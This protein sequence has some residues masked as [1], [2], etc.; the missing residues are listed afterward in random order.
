M[1]KIILSSL[2]CLFI[3]SGCSQINTDNPDKAFRYWT[4]IPLE[5]DQ[6]TVYKGKYWQSS[7]YSLEYEAYFIMTTTKEWKE[8]LIKLNEM[9][10][11]ST[12][13]LCPKDVPQW[14]SPP[15]NYIQYSSKRNYYLRMWEQ[16]EGDTIYI[17][18]FQV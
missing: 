17:Y 15:G 8:E 12:E 7:H 10:L 14:F 13:W 9:Q 2:I 5:N 16:V 1:K 3:I 18:D 11:D 6:V 4:Q